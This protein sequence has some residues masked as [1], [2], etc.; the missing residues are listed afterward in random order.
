M[1][2]RIA[3]FIENISEST[4]AGP[5]HGVFVRPRRRRVEAGRALM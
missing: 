5:L 1:K 3:P 2:R 4:A